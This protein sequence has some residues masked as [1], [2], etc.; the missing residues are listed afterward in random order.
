M[1]ILMPGSMQLGP[2][3]SAIPADLVAYLSSISKA[4]WYA[5]FLP[6]QGMAANSDGSGGSPAL[7]GAVGCW[8]AYQ[9][10]GWTAKFIQSTSASRP[11]YVSTTYGNAIAGNGSSW[12]LVLDSSTALNQD[13]TVLMSVIT[14]STSGYIF[15]HGNDAWSYYT[16]PNQPPVIYYNFDTEIGDGLD[17]AQSRVKPS[18]GAAWDRRRRVAMSSGSS[19]SRYGNAPRIIGGNG[20]YFSAAKI[21]QIAFVPKLTEAECQQAIRFLV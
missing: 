21:L 16:P 8:A 13:C 20:A 12:S 17:Q 7:N 19:T 3:G 10:T 11:Q 4:S 15:S 2:R 1:P 6:G 5:N 18:G 14:S 9:A